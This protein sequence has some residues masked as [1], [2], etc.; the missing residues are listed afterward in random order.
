MYMLCLFRT[1]DTHVMSRV[2]VYFQNCRESKQNVF[3]HTNGKSNV[4]HTNVHMST[5]KNADKGFCDTVIKVV[6]GEVA[7]RKHVS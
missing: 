5:S 1:I 4:R 2:T 3:V 6:V 7:I